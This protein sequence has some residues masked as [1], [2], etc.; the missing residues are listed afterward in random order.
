M[1]TL[2]LVLDQ[3]WR[4]AAAC[5]KVDPNVFFPD[6]HDKKK[7][8]QAKAICRVCPVRK[9]CLDFAI[10][11]CVDHGIWGGESERARVRMR[12]AGIPERSH[13]KVIT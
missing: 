9:Q 5:R 12:R 10:D 6:S 2:T 4:L 3:P 11:N 7:M 13:R 1:S 8:E